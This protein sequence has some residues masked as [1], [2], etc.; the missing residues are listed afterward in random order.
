MTKQP[1]KKPSI[2]ELMERGE[3][4][5]GFDWP[6][7][8]A[9]FDIRIARDG[10]WYYQDSPIE[11]FD[12]CRLF[13]TVLQKDAQGAYW[14]VTPA[15]RGR[16]A[17]EDVPFLA[18]EL[19]VSGTGAAQTLK[20]RTNMDHWI[21]AD[22]D[23]PIR[24][25]ADSATGEPSPYVMVRDGLEARLTRA[26]FYE[27]VGLAEEQAQDVETHYVVHSAGHAFT[28]GSVE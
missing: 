18:V 5:S 7:N 24:V 11:R 19:Q 28:L 10:T 26:V 27:L 14:L 16:I 4:L 2:K 20:F 9:D 17:V 12:I 21:T 25:V 13:S 8:Y 1:P 22:G 3:G 23:H 6:E 15:E